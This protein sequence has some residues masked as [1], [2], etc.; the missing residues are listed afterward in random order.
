MQ[1]NQASAIASALTLAAAGV[2]CGL[3][4]PASAGPKPAPAVDETQHTEAALRAIVDHWGDAEVDGDVAYLEQLLLPEYR[5][6]DAK[7]GSHPRA[8][9]LE[10]AR[11]NAG[12]AEARKAVDAFK[13]AHPTEVS[14]VIHGDT[15]IVSYFNPK[16]GLDSSI[17]GSDIFVFEARRWHA[18][19]SLHNGAE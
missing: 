11:T 1:R 16:R 8:R 5:S 7:G 14:V 3:P 13:L 4:A 12:S 15:G 10:H 9:I 2:L 6:I 19:Y 18:V 17:R